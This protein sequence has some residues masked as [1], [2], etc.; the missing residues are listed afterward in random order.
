MA[1]ITK[2]PSDEEPEEVSAENKAAA[3]STREEKPEKPARRWIVPV[4][5]IVVLLALTAGLIAGGYWVF[6]HKDELKEKFFPPNPA[7]IEA[8]QLEKT[9]KEESTSFFRKL[10]KKDRT[11]TVRGTLIGEE[12][13]AAVLI[14]EKVVPQ[15]SLVNGIRILEIT[16]QSV[17]VETGGLKRRLQVGESFDPDEK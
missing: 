15:G 10:I 14:N 6:V 17:V 8:D 16:N 3:A 9:P 5:L 12:G 13:G 11:I 4:V 1:L 7:Q 2:T